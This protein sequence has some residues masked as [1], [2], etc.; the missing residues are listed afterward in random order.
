MKT[1]L[2]TV[3]ATLAL[4]TAVATTSQAKIGD[5]FIDPEYGKIT[6]KGPAFENDNGKNRDI[7]DGKLVATDTPESIYMDK[8]GKVGLRIEKTIK[9]IHPN[10]TKT[11][12][13]AITNEFIEI[14]Q[15]IKGFRKTFDIDGYNKRML[16]MYAYK[17]RD[18]QRAIKYDFWDYFMK[19]KGTPE[20]EQL[21]KEINFSSQIIDNLELYKE[22]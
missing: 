3:F 21:K 13:T 17:I 6:V 10:L 19:I 2:F 12:I 20:F 8:N 4:S 1:N 11:E 5:T 22:E 16:G 14:F 9:K 7:V 15:T 18:A